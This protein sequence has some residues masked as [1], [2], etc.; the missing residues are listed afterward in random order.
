MGQGISL[1]GKGEAGE[2]HRAGVGQG[3]PFTAEHS[4]GLPTGGGKLCAGFAQPTGP[5]CKQQC[6]ST[7]DE[8][9]GT[10]PAGAAPCSPPPPPACIV[11]D[12]STTDE[13]KGSRRWRFKYAPT[14]EAGG[15]FD[16]RQG[17]GLGAPG[18]TDSQARVTDAACRAT[19]AANHRC[20]WRRLPEWQTCNHCPCWACAG[21]SPPSFCACKP[22]RAAQR[23]A[24]QSAGGKRAAWAARAGQHV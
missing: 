7:Q 23:A 14:W 18:P 5:S 17:K 15:V 19:R 16:V 20:A 10:R 21:A 2:D 11:S 6:A 4:G 24:Q 8:S 22:Q 3:I 12:T 13:R 9:R 1:Q